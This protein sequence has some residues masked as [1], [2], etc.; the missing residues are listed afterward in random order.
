MAA[1]FSLYTGGR[2]S[3]RGYNARNTNI[4]PAPNH[5]PMIADTV[6]ASCNF[7]KKVQGCLVTPE[8][9]ILTQLGDL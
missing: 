9:A 6:H 8:E 3:G 7:N 1:F 4:A 5:T 2:G